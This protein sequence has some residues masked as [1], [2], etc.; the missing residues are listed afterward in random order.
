MRVEYAQKHSRQ[1]QVTSIQP[2]RKELAL[3]YFEDLLSL[4]ARSTEQISSSYAQGRLDVMK[5]LSKDLQSLLGLSLPTDSY[6]AFLKQLQFAITSKASSNMLHFVECDLSDLYALAANTQRFISLIE[7]SLA[8]EQQ[9]K[10]RNFR[11]RLR[12]TKNQ[13]LETEKQEISEAF[14]ELNNVGLDNNVL[15]YILA[16]KK[17]IAENSEGSFREVIKN[18]CGKE[19]RIGEEWEE[20]FLENFSFGMTTEDMVCSKLQKQQRK[21]LTEKDW[22][23]FQ[24]QRMKEKYRN[25]KKKLKIR[26][27]ELSELEKHLNKKNLDI[28]KDKD[29]VERLRD[30][31]YKEKN[32]IKSNNEAKT[33]LLSDAIFDLSRT[34][35]CSEMQGKISPITETDMLSDISYV[36]DSDTSFD[37]GAKSP[38]SCSCRSEFRTWKLYT[39]PRRCRSR[40]SGCA[41]KSTRCGTTARCCGRAQCCGTAPRTRRSSTF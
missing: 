4:S 14:R 15:M 10:I 28:V 6:L 2:A 31:Y 20:E 17:E 34:F 11:F 22:E 13:Y 39:K 37:C 23:K 41:K 21:L 24:V 1:L 32:R 36:S 3:M 18:E 9:L 8:V 12:V 25:K 33:K 27:Q 38:T 16:L 29:E 30:A 19:E 5:C 7:Q 35:D 40:R 26:A